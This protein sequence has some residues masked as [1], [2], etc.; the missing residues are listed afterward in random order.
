MLDTNGKEL[1]IGDVVSILPQYACYQRGGEYNYRIVGLVNH[2][3]RVNVEA[4]A[5][6]RPWPKEC[7]TFNQYFNHSAGVLCEDVRKNPF[8]CAVQDAIYGQAKEK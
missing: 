1:K 4:I 6:Y 3:D 7:R 8:L 2:Q 5:D